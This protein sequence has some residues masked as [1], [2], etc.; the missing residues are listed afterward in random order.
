MHFYRV[1]IYERLIVK[2]GTAP[3]GL[4]ENEQNRI[5]NKLVVRLSAKLKTLLKCSLNLAG[6]GGIYF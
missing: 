1:I 3:R 6:E 4:R 2:L 5:K